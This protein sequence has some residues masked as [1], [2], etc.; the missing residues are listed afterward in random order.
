MSLKKFFFVSDKKKEKIN[1]TPGE[2]IT[3]SRFYY[4]IEKINSLSQGYLL[5]V[6]LSILAKSATLDMKF[7]FI[8]PLLS[9]LIGFSF[10]GAVISC[11]KPNLEVSCI[12]F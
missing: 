4:S 6:Y 9:S 1:F 2:M 5:N 12:L 7:N 8:C 3:H 11:L 10:I